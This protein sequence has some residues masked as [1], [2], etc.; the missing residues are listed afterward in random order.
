MDRT[1]NSLGSIL[2]NMSALT[3]EKLNIALNIQKEN[4]HKLLGTILVENNFCIEADIKQALKIQKEHLIGRILFRKGI[5]NFRQINDSLDEQKK[6]GGLFGDI[7]V[8]KGYCT[9]KDIDLALEVDSR[10]GMLLLNKGYINEKQLE[11]A[12]LIKSKNED[13]LLGQITLQLG[14]VTLEQLESVIALHKILKFR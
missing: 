8:N 14:Y 5:V 12:L 7:L 4:S 11:N 3:S 10:I 1:E 13:I 6:T 2:I 9:E